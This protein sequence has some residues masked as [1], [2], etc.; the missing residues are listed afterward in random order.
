[1][2]V[3]WGD[4]RKRERDSDESDDDDGIGRT[5]T[6]EDR[7]DPGLFIR[8]NG[9][10]VAHVIVS[11]P[12]TTERLARSPRGSRNLPLLALPPPEGRAG[13]AD[14]C[15]GNHQILSMT[16]EGIL[17]V[18]DSVVW[19]CNFSPETIEDVFE[20]IL[21]RSDGESTPS[22]VEIPLPETFE[23]TG[24]NDGG[25]V[26]NRVAFVINKQM[27][28]FVNPIERKY[29]GC[30]G[31]VGDATTG[32]FITDMSALHEIQDRVRYVE[33]HLMAFDHTNALF[34]CIVLASGE[35]CITLLLVDYRT[36]SGCVDTF[37]KQ[38]FPTRHVLEDSNSAPIILDA[39]AGE[40]KDLAI[41]TSRL[42][43][44]LVQ[45]CI[46]I[47]SLDSPITRIIQTPD[48]ANIPR[49]LVLSR[50]WM[51]WEEERNARQEE[52]LCR[53]LEG[54]MLVTDS[55]STQPRPSARGGAGQLHWEADAGQQGVECESYYT[56]RVGAL[57]IKSPFVEIVENPGTS[58]E[59]TEISICD[60]LL[61]V[62]TPFV[63][64][65]NHLT[66]TSSA[67]RQLGY[68]DTKQSDQG[69]IGLPK[70]LPSFAA[71]A[72]LGPVIMGVQA[73]EFEG[74]DDERKAVSSQLSLCT[75]SD[76]SSVRL[77]VELGPPQRFLQPK[78]FSRMCVIPEVVGPGRVYVHLTDYR[79]HY[80]R[81]AFME[82]SNADSMEA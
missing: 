60:D 67:W 68:F 37:H 12:Q 4:T 26:H 3:D 62:R 76:F 24:V 13:D 33:P 75:T 79:Q 69:C 14:A 78:P 7:V 18:R 46:L 1:M 66:S 70:G 22:I 40:V 34:S 30:I 15:R 41:N 61:L 80:L 73:S 23:I 21:P 17:F 47:W 32:L 35:P 8:G 53:L 39:M 44:A 29:C 31:L 49:R 36:E 56:S 16:L 52:E 25:G 65:V 20:G 54:G 57:P 27:V 71:L 77:P 19:C 59:W 55:T 82:H 64:F 81:V 38:P 43:V 6:G 74:V 9:E 42:A 58:D 50:E 45:E 2:E 51:R 11:A 72:I 10:I 63:M 28:Y 48:W 5:C